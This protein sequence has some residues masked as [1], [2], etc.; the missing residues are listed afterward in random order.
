MAGRDRP[1]G[2][3]RAGSPETSTAASNFGMPPSRSGTSST[4]NRNTPPAHPGPFARPGAADLSNRSGSPL[5]RTRALWPGCSAGC[6]A[7]SKRNSPASATWCSTDSR[8]ALMSKKSTARVRQ[9]PLLHA[10]LT[11]DQAGQLGQLRESRRR[12]GR[13]VR[14]LSNTRTRRLLTCQVVLECLYQARPDAGAHVRH[15]GRD[16]VGQLDRLRHPGVSTAAS[17]GAMKL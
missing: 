7:A 8:S 13:K 4:S 15:V 16:R 17:S 9:A 14:P 12:S 3:S 11:I 1:A 10:R 6:S 2:Q 5:R